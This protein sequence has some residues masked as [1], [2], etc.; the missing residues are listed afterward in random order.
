MQTPR[1]YPSL[2]WVF[3]EASRVVQ[4]GGGGNEEGLQQL[5]L[6]RKRVTFSKPSLRMCVLTRDVFPFVECIYI[7]T[8]R[9]V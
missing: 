9:K 7:K 1:T 5:S 2:N 4:V 8:L 3:L 6:S